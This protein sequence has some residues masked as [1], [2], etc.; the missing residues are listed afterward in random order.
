MADDFA[1]DH[2]PYDGLELCGDLEQ[3][4]STLQQVTIYALDHEEFRQ[5]WDAGVRSAADQ[6]CAEIA[7]ARMAGRMTGVTSE[8]WADIP[9]PVSMDTQEVFAAF[10]LAVLGEVRRR[11]EAMMDRPAG[12]RG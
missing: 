1:P 10:S 9:V 2:D 12:G 7:G 3:A 8:S 11:L 5:Q 6:A 4:A